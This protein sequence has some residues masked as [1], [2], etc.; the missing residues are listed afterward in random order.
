MWSDLWSSQSM[1]EA[2]ISFSLIFIKRYLEN[3]LS[4]ITSRFWEV[5]VCV[6]TLQRNAVGHVKST[7][8]QFEGHWTWCFGIEDIMM[9][10][11]L[12]PRF[13]YS[14]R[15]K[16]TSTA[17]VVMSVNPREWEADDAALKAFPGI[18][19]LRSLMICLQCASFQPRLK[20]WSHYSRNKVS[21]NSH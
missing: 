20:T 3:E 8:P 14:W 17:R 13:D 5:Y 10:L 9:R 7:R 4:W 2:R 11:K 15:R 16:R 6:N 21:N 1:L 19:W 18:F 12:I